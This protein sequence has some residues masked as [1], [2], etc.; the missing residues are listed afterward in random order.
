MTP[1]IS[2]DCTDNQFVYIAIQH[3]NSVAVDADNK[4]FVI[5]AVLQWYYNIMDTILRATTKIHQLTTSII[6]IIIVNIII[7]DI[8]CHSQ[9]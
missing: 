5:V 1:N 8:V 9:K 4:N 3:K 2:G 6:I 7:M